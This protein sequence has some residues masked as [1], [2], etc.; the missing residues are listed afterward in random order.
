MKNRAREPKYDERYISACIGA[1]RLLALRYGYFT[2]AWN[3]LVQGLGFGDESSEGNS[4]SLRVVAALVQGR[5]FG[6][7]DEKD[8]LQESIW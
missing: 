8:A 7:G 3:V 4:D 6:S 5:D 2:V 1:G